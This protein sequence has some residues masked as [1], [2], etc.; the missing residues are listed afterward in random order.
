MIS[1][2]ATA[3]A[4]WAGGPVRPP[5]HVLTDLLDN[6]DQDQHNAEVAKL[7]DQIAQAKEDLVAEDE[8]LTAERAVLDAQAQ[9]IQADSFRLP[10]DQNASNEVMRRRRWSRLPPVSEARNLF[11]TPGAGTSDPPGVNRVIAALGLECRLNHARRIRLVR[12]M[13]HHSMSQRLRVI[14]LT[15]W[16]MIRLQRIYNF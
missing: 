16:I 8:R 6:Q 11:N 3:T 15:R 13:S 12:T 1:G 5:A 4:A 9:R 2:S 14:T 7:R 10:L